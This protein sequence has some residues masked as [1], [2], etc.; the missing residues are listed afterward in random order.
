M[1]ARSILAVLAACALLGTAMHLANP[2]NAESS[3]LYSHDTH[4][5]VGKPLTLGLWG[6]QDG[7]STRVKVQVRRHGK[8]LVS[9]RI[10]AAGTWKNYK[11]LAHPHAGNYSVYLYGGGG[12][13]G[14]VMT[15]R[16]VG[17][18]CTPGYSP[19]IP[20]GPDV[21]CAGGSG[22]GPRYIQGPVYVTGSDPY[23]LDADSDGIGCES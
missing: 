8:L 21:D 3:V 16:V 1:S 14:Y 20:P 23:G 9:R 13:D 15:I 12:W 22:N 18:S 17:Q 19:C 10:N 6:R 4:S 11:L 2:Q 7:E 5:V